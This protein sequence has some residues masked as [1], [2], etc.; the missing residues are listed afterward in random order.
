MPVRKSLCG[1]AGTADKAHRL[2]RT[3]QLIYLATGVYVK[4]MVAV[5]DICRKYWISVSG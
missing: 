5:R 1:Q 4:D 3:I 2:P